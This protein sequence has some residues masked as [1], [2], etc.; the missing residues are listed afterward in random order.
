MINLSKPWPLWIGTRWWW[1]TVLA[2]LA[3]L[4]VVAPFDAQISLWARTW[5]AD[6]HA[7]F[8]SITDFGLADWILWPAGVL[9]IATAIL[10]RFVRWRLMA[11]MLRQF[12]V[13]YGFIFVGVAAPSLVTTI[14]KRVIGRAR[15]EHLV[16]A[17]PFA[18][19]PNIVDW[20]YQSFP[21]GHTTTIFAL[22]LV[23]AFLSPRLL[24]LALAFA[25]A[26]GVSRISVNAHYPT[27]AIAGAYMGV[28]GAYLVR[29]FFAARGWMFVIAPDGT[30]ESRPL[31]SLRRYLVLKRRGNAPARPTSPI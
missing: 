16:D 11:T 13:L 12:A 15:P 24:W 23:V 2:C 22:A 30:I 9:F 31:S 21:S 7:F 19:R 27:D 17:G 5:P 6:V 4:V 18:F 14:I 25:A 26:V 8:A 20:G 28:L 10:A 29:N 1:A 3:V